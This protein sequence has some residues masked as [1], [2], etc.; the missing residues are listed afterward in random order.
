ML[1]EAEL[2]IVDGKKE[3]AR[4]KLRQAKKWIDDKGMHRWDTEV[5]RLQEQC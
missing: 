1:I 3:A 2:A 5:E 4:K